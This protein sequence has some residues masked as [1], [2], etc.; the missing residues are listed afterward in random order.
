MGG[1]GA[2]TCFEFSTCQSATRFNTRPIHNDHLSRVRGACAFVEHAEYRAGHSTN[3]AM[4]FLIASRP[5][6]ACPLCIS[7]L[8]GSDA[9]PPPQPGAAPKEQRQG[10][11]WQHPVALAAVP[12]VLR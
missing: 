10:D 5:P 2:L 4:L 9:A 12:L 11:R 3:P 1:W 8:L 6:L 7:H